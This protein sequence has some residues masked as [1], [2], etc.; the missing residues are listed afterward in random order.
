M[1][2]AEASLVELLASV[3]EYEPAWHLS[4]VLGEDG[5]LAMKA[6]ALGVDVC[7]LPMPA[8]LA[9]VGDSGSNRLL[10]I[11]AG[12]IAASGY[13][14]RLTRVLQAARPHL[15]HATGFKMHMLSAWTRPPGIPLIWHIH[16]YLRSRPMMSRLLRWQA[17]RCSAV[18][19]NS[20]S[21]AED[22]RVGLGQHLPIETVYNA[23]DLRRFSPE[24]LTLN[25]DVLSG[26]GPAE[27]G[28]IRVGLVATFARWKGHS[29]FLNALS[30]LSASSR[31]RGYVI[32]GPIYKTTGSQHSIEA[33]R[34]ET[35]RLGLAGRVGFTGFVDDTACAMRALDVVVHA[36]TEPE[37]FGM[38]IVEGM[39]C[40]KAVIASQAGGAT[41]IFEQGVDAMAHPPGDFESLAKR[42]TRLACDKDL[43]LRLGRAGRAKVE[44]EFNGERLARAIAGVYRQHCVGIPIARDAALAANS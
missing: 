12:S 22:I 9:R 16:D 17:S 41:E 44:K 42:I 30:R 25:L 28:T 7:V 43:R 8:S 4:L 1:G 2:G 21:V 6:A 27:P 23:I 5:P 20:R 37:P 14:R 38:V 26:L 40:G 15:I 24:G 11:G 19:V 33:L 10:G 36:S 32:G 3:R 34:L 29:V 31:V 35:A 18:I 39:A 13:A